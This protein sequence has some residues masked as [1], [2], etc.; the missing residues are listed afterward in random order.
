MKLTSAA[1][2]CS[3][4]RTALRAFRDN[5]R[6][7]LCGSSAAAGAGQELSAET[8]GANYARPGRRDQHRV[9]MHTFEHEPAQRA[10]DER[11]RMPSSSNPRSPL[12]FDSYERNRTTGSFI[13]IDPLSNATVGA[14]ML[15]ENQLETS[16]PSSTSEFHPQ[17]LAPT[18]VTAAER[19][20]RHG[21]R[22]AIV[23]AEG[24]LVL[25][26]L[27][28]RALFQRGY[29]VLLATAAD[30]HSPRTIPGAGARNAGCR[31]DLDLFPSCARFVGQ[32][33][34]KHAGRG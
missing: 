20:T 10:E 25:A 18:P 31:T 2:T 24:R 3:F 15:G 5:F 9:N 22:S 13:L 11:H 33:G 19:F 23:L 12:F 26:S 17:A 14:A 27:L 21:H 32:A 30:A 28:E 29:E 34:A 6:R 4:R 7:W 16:S 1:E 8:Y